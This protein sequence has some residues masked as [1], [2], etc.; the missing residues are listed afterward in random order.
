[1][2]S[3]ITGPIIFED[4]TYIHGSH[5]RP[6]NWTDDNGSSL[7][8]LS[9][10]EG[11]IVHGGAR[12]GFISHALLIYKS[13]QKTGDYNNEKDSTNYETML[14][15]NLAPN[16]I[17]VIDNASYHYIQRDKLHSPTLE[18]QQFA[19]KNTTFKVKDV[20]QLCCQRFKEIGK[21]ECDNVYKHMEKL[22]LYC[23]QKR[24]IEDTTECIITED[25]RVDISDSSDESSEMSESKGLSAVV[26]IKL[27]NTLS[28][29]NFLVMCNVAKLTFL[30]YI[31]W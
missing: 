14:I 10:G 12:D 6:R 21:E 4:E 3:E 27:T 17:L 11:L 22:E 13:R 1:M 16:S 28:S 7:L 29:V 26:E 19:S 8:V 23:E 31:L 24:I 30:C 20:E 18:K 2:H 9:K 15:P 25:N 5:T